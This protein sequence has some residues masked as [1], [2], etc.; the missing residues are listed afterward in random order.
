M[1][2]QHSRSH[3]Q[4]GILFSIPIGHWHT[5]STVFLFH[6][7]IG[8]LSKRCSSKVLK[9]H[10][11][12][13]CVLQYI[14]RFLCP[15]L[16][17]R[18]TITLPISLFSA[19][20]TSATWSTCTALNSPPFYTFFGYPLFLLI[21]LTSAGPSAYHVPNG[22][23]I[24]F[25]S[26]FPYLQLINLSLTRIHRMPQQIYHQFASGIPSSPLCHLPTAKIAMLPLFPPRNFDRLFSEELQNFNTLLAVSLFYLKSPAH[27]PR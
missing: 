21:S 24:I 11:L 3:I 18:R 12:L 6:L 14:S 25:F 27:Q 1:A 22:F 23:R 19:I 13:E 26:I 7:L 20:H 10:L 4:N 16:L 8:Y 15:T 5:F 9:H 17:K 2:I